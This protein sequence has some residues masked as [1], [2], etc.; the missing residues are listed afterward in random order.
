MVERPPMSSFE[1]VLAD[2]QKIAPGLVPS[3]QQIA[4]AL[5][6]VI[7]HLEQFADKELPRLADELLGVAP[8]APTTEGTATEG[9]A[10]AAEVPPASPPGSVPMS[11]PSDV[12]LQERIHELEEENARL[13]GSPAARAPAPSQAMGGAQPPASTAPPSA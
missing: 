10:A 4:G 9:T 3:E 2:A 6:V 1:N 7:A 8:A 11:S 5:G 13:S 12:A